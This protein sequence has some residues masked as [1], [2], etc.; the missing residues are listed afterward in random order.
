MYGLIILVIYTV[1]MLTITG[2][3]SKP[4]LNTESFHVANRETG[5]LQGALPQPG[6]G[7]RHCLHQQKRLMLTAGRAYFGFWFLMFYACCFLFLLP[8]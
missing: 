2:L 5:T 4:A 8:E 1:I 7:R 6:Y 3:F